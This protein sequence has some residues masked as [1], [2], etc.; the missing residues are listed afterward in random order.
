MNTKSP[1]EVEKK[2]KKCA[3]ESR[4]FRQW[5]PL[6]HTCKHMGGWSVKSWS[7]A[8]P[9]FPV[10]VQLNT[11]ANS[12]T[13]MHV[14]THTHPVGLKEV[15]LYLYLAQRA[16]PHGQLQYKKPSLFCSSESLQLLSTALPS[17]AKHQYSTRTS[18]RTTVPHQIHRMKPKRLL[19]LVDPLPTISEMQEDMLQVACQAHNAHASDSLDEYVDSIKELARPSFGPLRVPRSQRPRL[20]TK[21]PA[22]PAPKAYRP[23]LSTCVD[24]T[25]FRSSHQRDCTRDPLDW[26]FAQPL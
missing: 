19:L 20:F 8:R 16:L 12:H 6:F 3:R 21:A 22:R 2:K 7:A 10:Q 1:K 23:R 17:T 18:T 5:G 13:Y 25:K 24:D 26:L 4:L 9:E 15:S 14:H 11:R